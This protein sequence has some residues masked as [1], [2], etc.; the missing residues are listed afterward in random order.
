MRHAS[1]V[2]RASVAVIV[3]MSVGACAASTAS[4]STAPTAPAA[5]ANVAAAGSAD[6]VQSPIASTRAAPSPTPS[7]PAGAKIDGRIQV[8]DPVAPRWFAADDTSLWVHQPTSL[9]RVDLAT[10]AVTGTVPLNWM[11]YGYD[12]TGAGS[13]WQTDYENDVLVRIDPVAGKLVTSIPVASA[14]AGVA[15]TE[16]SVWVAN[17]H[18]GSVQRVDPA[19]NHVIATITVGPTGSAG[20]Q[21]L[22]AGPGGVW[23]D[24]QN[25]Q[26]VVRV[27]AATNTVGLRVPMEGWVASDGTEVWIG[28]AGGPNGPSRVVRIDPVTGEVITS[29]HLGTSD[30]IGGLAVGLGSVW[31]SSGG[32]L[33][34]IDTETGRIVGHL[35]LG[36]DGGNVVVAGGAVWVAANGHQYVLRNSPP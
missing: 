36:G 24:I 13:V 11:D 25:N 21:I 35:D 14:P 9:V 5:S 32:G 16:G 27:D 17:E 29:V 8:G 30:D 6:A 28:I 19:T 23:V 34:R 2:L 10:S 7:F 12:T 22:T 18:N 33:T 15:V 4:P 26:S 20:P 31:A 3:A 1:V